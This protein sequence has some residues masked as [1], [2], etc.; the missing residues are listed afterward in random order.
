MVTKY[1]YKIRRHVGYRTN[2]SC[3]TRRGGNGSD[4]KTVRSIKIGR[5][6]LT[7]YIM[8]SC[9][10]EYDVTKN[11]KLQWVLMTEQQY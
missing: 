2:K 7:N 11:Y 4:A 9:P 6:N 10:V 5:G 1:G 3:R 8:I